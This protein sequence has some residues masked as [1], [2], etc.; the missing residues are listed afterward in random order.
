MLEQAEAAAGAGAP[1]SVEQEPQGL[2]APA[3]Q[4]DDGIEDG[5]GQ[6]AHGLVETERDRLIRLVSILHPCTDSHTQLLKTL[7]P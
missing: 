4:V 7:M 3:E 1:R 2:P 5:A 6:G